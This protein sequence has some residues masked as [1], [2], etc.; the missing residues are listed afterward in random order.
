[1][2]I[3]MMIVNML[4]GFLCNGEERIE[5]RQV[6]CYQSFEPFLTDFLTNFLTNCLANLLANLV[7]NILTYINGQQC[8]NC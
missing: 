8:R 2:D 4:K 7:T 6:G 3:I 1:M 5:E